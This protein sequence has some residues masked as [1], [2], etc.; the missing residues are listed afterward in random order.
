MSNPNLRRRLDCHQLATW[1]SRRANGTTDARKPAGDD[2]RA[3]MVVCPVAGT[4]QPTPRTCRDAMGPA[5]ATSVRARIGL[6]GDGSR[7]LRRKLH[8]GGH[9]QDAT[10]ARSGR[11]RPGD[12]P[13][14][15]LPVARLR[16]QNARPHWVDTARDRSGDVGDEPLLL[17]AAH[18]TL[19]CRDRA[20]GARA[21]V[22]GPVSAD[23]IIMDDGLQNPG[24][25]K[26]LTVAVVDGMRG[27][28]NGRVI[29]P[30][31]CAR[32]SR[33]SSPWS[34]PSSSTGARWTARRQ[35]RRR[36]AGE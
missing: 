35:C 23:V 5:R 33:S 28:G 24:V 29:P 31:R 3:H 21:I 12:G 26:D 22:E 19:V 10:R 36:R 9:R 7:H 16:R 1:G 6:P 13:Q 25:A 8:R 18:P 30:G 27:I 15:R 4:G 17:A 20:V 32:R 14:G 2:A 34:M 11:P